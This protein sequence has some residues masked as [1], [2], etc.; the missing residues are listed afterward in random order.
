LFNRTL[1]RPQK[2][3]SV[4]RERNAIIGVRH[5]VWHGA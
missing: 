4:R 2:L 5:G 1:Q 3:G